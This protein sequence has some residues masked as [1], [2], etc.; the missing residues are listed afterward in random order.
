MIQMFPFLKLAN[1]D[2]VV[3]ARDK[4]WHAFTSNV[5]GDI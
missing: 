2:A 1:N 4:L 5:A 3:S